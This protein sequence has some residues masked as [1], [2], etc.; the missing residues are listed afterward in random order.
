ME[1]GNR[2]AAVG[3]PA[4]G[5]TPHSLRHAGM[6]MWLRKGVDLKLIQA[7]GGWHSLKVMLDTYAALLPGA[8]EDSIALLEGGRSS[9][10]TG[11][12]PSARSLHRDRPTGPGPGNLHWSLQA[13]PWSG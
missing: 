4:Q 6:T 7:W 5:I 3:P 12:F 11:S 9:P 2:R 13:T 10:R 1:P 8:E